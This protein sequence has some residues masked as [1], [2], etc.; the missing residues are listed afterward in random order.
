MPSKLRFQPRRVDK[1][2]K[3]IADALRALGFG[4]LDIH[5]V[6]RGA[7][8]L[9]VS[10]ATD[11]VLVEVKT[12]GEGFTEDETEFAKSW[13]CNIIIAI[14]EHDVTAWFAMRRKSRNRVKLD[15]AKPADWNPIPDDDE[16]LERYRATTDK[17]LK[18][19]ANVR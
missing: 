5:S 17:R 4:V 8:D 14:T 18:S 2:Q 10:N 16:M 1:N 11:T 3:A 13:P 15:G 9:V 12:L 19:Q 6:G 7:P